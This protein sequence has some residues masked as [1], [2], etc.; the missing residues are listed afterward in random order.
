MAAKV[1]GN[2]TSNLF[3]LLSDDAPEPTVVASAPKVK[4]EAPAKKPAAA[5]APEKDAAGAAL[6][7][8]EKAKLREAKAIKAPKPAQERAPRRGTYLIYIRE[9]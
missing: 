5:A 7:P 2:P 6:T 8:A 9:L 1:A 3:S 4:K